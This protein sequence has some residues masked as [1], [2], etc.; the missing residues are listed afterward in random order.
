LAE[1]FPFRTKKYAFGGILLKNHTITFY[2]KG[3]LSD[4]CK[5]G[6]WGVLCKQ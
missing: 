2:T 5:E 3:V 6:A 4:I 1:D